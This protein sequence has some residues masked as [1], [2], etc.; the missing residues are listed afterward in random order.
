MAA[1][2]SASTA[3][4]KAN[5]AT[6]KASEASSSASTATTKANDASA[7]AT[8]A[9]G[10]ASTATTKASE[11][12]SSATS[13]SGSA[14]TATTKASEASS[15]ASAAASSASSASS[16]ATTAV[17]AVIDTA[18]A[19]LN[20]LNELAAALGDD[21][22]YA[23]TT[24]TALGNRYTKTETD[25]RIVALSPPAT[26]SHVDSL[27]INAG[28]LD[29]L[30]STKFTRETA[31]SSASVGAGWITVAQSQG[32]RHRG[33]VIVSDSES[34]DH[35]YIRIEWMRSY[36]DSNFTVITC[37]GHGN[38]ITG[39]RVLYETADNVYGV[40]LLQVYVTVSSIYSVQV[41]E[42]APVSGWNGHTVVTP[43]V[44]NTI[45]GYAVHGNELTGLDSY[46]LASE[47][48][49]L[50]GGNIKA[51][52]FI[53]DGSALT[54]VR[55]IIIRDNA[56]ASGTN[57]STT[58]NVWVDSGLAITIT[59]ASANSYF[60]VEF[61]H[62]SHINRNTPNFGGASRILGGATEI[63]RGGE[64][65]HQTSAS[66]L[67][68]NGDKT[69]YGSF[70]NPNTAAA[71][72]FKAQVVSKST[73]TESYYWHWGAQTYISGAAEIGPRIR[74]IEFL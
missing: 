2:V 43:I 64:Y 19:N 74:V 65:I 57:Y 60:Y 66:N 56:G 46:S 38:R 49:I 37:G 24:T 39:A 42:P 62:N 26:K 61:R 5:T 20:T 69:H 12:S 47:E 33:E 50:A 1:G 35:A 14:S 25:A 10:S 53:G 27:G 3:T 68:Y 21:A 34:S 29:G 17:N 71:I 54:G 30:N 6:T 52:A 13:A 51:N 8:S 28:T 48:G 16:A 11:A 63:A 7:S 41:F 55:N 18:P 9:S 73:G 23:S 40:K 44:Q 15:S 22:N 59:P 45:T 31:S 67:D 32:G 72:V 58:S 70:Y 4:T 36:V